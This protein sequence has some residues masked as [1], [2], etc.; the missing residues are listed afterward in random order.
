[1]E[2]AG[3]RRGDVVLEVGSQ[4]IESTED[5]RDATQGLEKG[6]PMLLLVRRG[7][8]TIFLTLKLE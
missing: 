3:M 1:A 5:F 8:N 2:S 4:K 7:T 6:K